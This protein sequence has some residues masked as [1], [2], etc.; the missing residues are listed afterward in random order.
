MFFL[1]SCAG[2]GPVSKIEHDGYLANVRPGQTLEA[3]NK[4]LTKLPIF[5]SE[6]IEHNGDTYQVSVFEKYTVVG[7]GQTGSVFC[8]PTGCYYGAVSNTSHYMPFFFVFSDSIGLMTWGFKEEIAYAKPE[9]KPVMEEL[10][11]NAN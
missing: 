7:Q 5:V 2:T 3:V 10:F 11:K 4:S 9:L 6:K 8:T 1:V